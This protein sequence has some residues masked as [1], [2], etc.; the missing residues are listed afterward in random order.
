[1]KPA[2]SF[3][4]LC[5]FFHGVQRKQSSSFSA[6]ASHFIKCVMDLKVLL[7]DLKSSGE[8][9]EDVIPGMLLHFVGKTVGIKYTD[10]QF[11]VVTP[12]ML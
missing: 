9:S 8:D 1:M 11:D 2:Q 3:Q 10:K 5:N 12:A 6:T 4:D 7:C